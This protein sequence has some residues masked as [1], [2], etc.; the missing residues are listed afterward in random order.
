[1]QCKRVKKFD[2]WGSIFNK[3]SKDKKNETIYTEIS[4]YTR[5]INCHSENFAKNIK[6]CQKTTLQM[7]ILSLQFCLP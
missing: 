1:M 3:T 2:G 7:Q 4:M 5:V 6:E